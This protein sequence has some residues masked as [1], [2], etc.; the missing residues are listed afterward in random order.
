MLMYQR[1]LLGLLSLAFGCP[2]GLADTFSVTLKAVDADRKPIARAEVWGV[3]GGAM[4][5]VAEKPIVT[6]AG[7]K[8]LLTVDNGNLKRAVLVL[9]RSSA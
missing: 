1:S 2:T 7:G 4:M 6:D 8:A 3:K 9:S 5:A